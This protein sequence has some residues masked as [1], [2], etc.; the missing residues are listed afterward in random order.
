MPSPARVTRTPGSPTAAHTPTPPASEISVPGE[1]VV[2]PVLLY[3]NISD[4]G[5]SPYTVR[6]ADFRRQMQ[7]LHE[8]GYQAITISE[9]ADAIRGEGSLPEK[10]VVITFDDGFLGVYDNAFPVLQ[11]YGFRGVVYVITGTLGTDQAYG[12]LQEQELGELIENGWEIGSHSISHSSLKTTQLGLGNEIE[13]SRKDLEKKLGTLVRSFAYPYNIT[14][15]WIAEQVEE[16]GYES[17]VGVDIFV[18]HPPE[19]LYF[20]SRRE[21]TGKTSLAGFRTLLAPGKYEIAVLAQTT[22]TPEE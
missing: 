1:R 6:V 18:S 9:L 21:V 20:L 11:E 12:Y 3:H 15:A 17:A 8:E 2:A 19:R 5:S 10:V 4:R 22:A 16:Y 14:N 13:G 7:I